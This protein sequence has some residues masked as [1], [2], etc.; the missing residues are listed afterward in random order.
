[1]ARAGPAFRPRRFRDRGSSARAC[2]PERSL[3]P[4]GGRYASAG[5]SLLRLRT[6]N[7]RLGQ[8]GGCVGTAITQ[9]RHELV[10]VVRIRPV[11]GPR[12]CVLKEDGDGLFVIHRNPVT[13]ELMEKETA[14]VVAERAPAR[15]LRL[16]G[17]PVRKQLRV[18]IEGRRRGI[19]GFQPEVVLFCRAALE[20]HVGGVSRAGRHGKHRC[21]RGRAA[22]EEQADDQRTTRSEAH[23]RI[24]SSGTIMKKKITV[25]AEPISR[26][27]D[28]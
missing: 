2:R 12:R 16:T 15:F 10:V 26:R 20:H 1:M 22:R 17:K 18:V 25:Y 28:A 23:C 5:G 14:L 24:T 21:R 19:G 8:E 4:A 6:F 7:A 3:P 9:Y 27:I 13:R 11:F